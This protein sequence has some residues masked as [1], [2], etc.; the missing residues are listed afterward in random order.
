MK[1][2]SL[3]IEP[4]DLVLTAMADRL[5][6]KAMEPEVE[7]ALCKWLLESP[8]HRNIYRGVIDP[9]PPAWIAVHQ[10]FVRRDPKEIKG[11]IG[12]VA[13][14]IW[15]FDK[16]ILNVVYM[17]KWTKNEIVRAIAKHPNIGEKEIPFRVEDVAGKL[18]VCVPAL[19]EHLQKSAASFVKAMGQEWQHQRFFFDAET[20]KQTLFKYL[21]EWRI[22]K[23]E[24]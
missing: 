10:N 9:N 16:R 8:D 6:G 22:E 23:I 19:E 11:L 1:F 20:G 2:K 7:D 4:S 13:D 18:V 21:I 24:L 5:R 17:P 12:I 14:C 15:T 3:L